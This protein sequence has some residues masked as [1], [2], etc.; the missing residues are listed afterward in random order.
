MTEGH[1]KNAVTNKKILRL[2]LLEIKE[3]RVN[4]FPRMR[5]RS[6]LIETFKIINEISNHG[7]HFLNISPETVNLLWRQI[8]KEKSL[9]TKWIFFFC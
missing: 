7:R 5:I 1:I 2:K 6:D 9:W 4:Y 8:K 3:I